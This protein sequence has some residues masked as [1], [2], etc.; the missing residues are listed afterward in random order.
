MAD[1]PP[2]YF[3]QQIGAPDEERYKKFKRTMMIIGLISVVLL[4]IFIGAVVY[5][6]SLYVP[7]R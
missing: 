1:R 3:P 4:T 7:S 5:L 6:L 2:P